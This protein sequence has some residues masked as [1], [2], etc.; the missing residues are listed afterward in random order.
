MFISNFGEITFYDHKTACGIQSAITECFLNCYSLCKY[1]ASLH[2][3][4]LND[5]DFTLTQFLR[6]EEGHLSPSHII[7]WICAAY[8]YITLQNTFTKDNTFQLPTNIL[9]PI[10]LFYVDQCRCILLPYLCERIIRYQNSALSS[11]R[12]I[13]W[14]D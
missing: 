13:D 14:Q 9:R 8:Y 6:I 2:T 10:C 1:Y 5:I 4:F 12:G 7:F 3:R 11:L